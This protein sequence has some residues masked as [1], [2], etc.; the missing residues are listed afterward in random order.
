MVAESARGAA[1]QPGPD[2]FTR[3]YWDAAAQGRLLLRRCADCG[4]AHHHPREFC[5][6]CWSEEVGWEDAGGRA[7]LY[8]WSEVHA[9]DLPPFRDRLPCIAV[10]VNLEEGPR[11]TTA[12][13]GCPA[14]ELRIGMA[15]AVSFTTGHTADS[16]NMH[17]TCVPVFTPSD[18]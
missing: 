17:M 16:L 11:M 7:T 4:R 2:A 9:N 18:R 1:R 12:V 5:S 15:L 13:V 14:A 6:Y 10:V 8:T 3:V